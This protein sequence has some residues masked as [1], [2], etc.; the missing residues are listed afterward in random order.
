MNLLL[1]RRKKKDKEKKNSR[2]QALEANVGTV[3]KW[4]QVT[5]S[6][7]FFLKVEH[8]GYRV[9]KRKGGFVSNFLGKEMRERHRKIIYSSPIL[10]I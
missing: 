9:W 7:R 5:V 1:L 6:L 3:Q 10:S 4:G 8:Q 2:Y